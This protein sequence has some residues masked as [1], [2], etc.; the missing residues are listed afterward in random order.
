MC[1][2]NSACFSELAPQGDLSR[3]IQGCVELIHQSKQELCL[4]RMH[5]AKLLPVKSPF[6]LCC[7]EDMCNYIDNLDL[8]IQVN[9]KANHS[10]G[11]PGSD[12][13]G[14]YFGNNQ[15]IALRHDL[16]FK[17]AVIA[18]PI[19]GG[20]ILILL[21]LLAMHML[22]KDT[23]RQRQMLELRRQRQFKA[24]LLL[25]DHYVTDLQDLYTDQREHLTPDKNRDI[26]YPE[27]NETNAKLNRLESQ[28]NYLYKN[29]NLAL[30]RDST[31]NEKQYIYDK[32]FRNTLCTSLVPWSHA[33][34]N[35]STPV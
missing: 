4:T 34:W 15:D 19:A 25:G 11:P 18:V 7:A 22:R 1:K 16:W 2:S 27:K 24:Q 6:L 35:T 13:R 12:D 30:S 26:F 21:V 14:F 28:S 3:S 31:F 32:K 17:A 10:H 29:V 20:F 23:R 8:H 9:T 5:A 33:H